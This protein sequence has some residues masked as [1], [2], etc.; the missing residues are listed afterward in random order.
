MKSLK[1]NVT[2]FSY[3]ITWGTIS[4]L[5]LH[6]CPRDRGF[7]TSNQLLNK[8]FPDVGEFFTHKM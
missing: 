3:W 4:I 6:W 1:M 5:A 7:D 8:S 2:R